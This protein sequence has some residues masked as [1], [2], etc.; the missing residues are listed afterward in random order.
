MTESAAPFDPTDKAFL[1]IGATGHVGSKITGLLAE[2]GFNV[3]AMVRKPGAMIRD[4]YNGVI[5]YAVGDLTDERSIKAALA[6]ID[7]VIS[8]ANGIIPQKAGDT[9]RSVN[10]AAERLITLCE[11]AGVQ[12]FVQ[13]SVPSY[14]RENSVPE[15]RGKRRIERRLLASTMQSVIIR[16]PAFMDVFIPLGG[17]AGATDRSLHAT[18]QRNYGFVRFYSALVGDLVEKR[19]WFIAPG[20]A[21]HGTPMISTR[22]VAQMIVGAAMAPDRDNILIEAGGPEWLTWR[23]IAD[24]IGQKTGRRI[25][26]IPLPGWLAR[27][28]QALATPVSAPAANIIAL[29]GFVAAFQPRWTS[30]DVVRRFDL[31]PQLTLA[32]YLDLNYAQDTSGKT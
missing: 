16:N 5:H 25:R 19:G 28:N 1:V 2:K 13:S 3:T 7:V 14:R 15:L 20:G 11:D 4:P 18:T 22:D 27:L 26:L 23:Q 30:E 29:M 24:I 6:G 21:N 12:R 8:T 10:A 17:F 31:P 9:A 32:D